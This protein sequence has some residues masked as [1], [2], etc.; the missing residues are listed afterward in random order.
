M[1]PEVI[2]GPLF[3][4]RRL[5]L[6]VLENMAR[7]VKHGGPAWDAGLGEV[8]KVALHEANLPNAMSAVDVARKLGVLKPVRRVNGA[9]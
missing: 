1:T 4:P 8:V 5:I 7:R 3:D 6:R 9:R 2:Q